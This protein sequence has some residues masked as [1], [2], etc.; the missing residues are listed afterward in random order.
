MDH[1]GEMPEEFV[2]IG[3]KDGS[4]R[5]VCDFLS[6]M[7]DRYAVRTYQQLFIPAAFPVN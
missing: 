3:Y 6:C 1:P 7:T 4:A 2:L 5:G